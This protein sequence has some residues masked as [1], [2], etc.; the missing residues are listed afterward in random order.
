[1][2]ILH[3]SDLHGELMKIVHNKHHLLSKFDVWIDTGDFFPNDP[4]IEFHMSKYGKPHRSWHID[5]KHEEIFQKRWLEEKDILN[6]LIKW[7]NGRPFVSVSGNH[8]FISLAESLK[9]HGYENV[10]DINPE[11]F[12]LF[13]FKWAGFPHVMPVDLDGPSQWNHE[14][15]HFTML[16]LIKRI[17]ESQP[18]ILIT[19]SPP[20]NILDLGGS[21]PAD[22]WKPLGIPQISLSLSYKPNKILAHFFGHIHE[23]GGKKEYVKDLDITFYNGARHAIMHEIENK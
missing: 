9:E 4:I 16:D 2:K 15:D 18:D 8:D 22:N 3:T 23:Q 20:G 21:G 5:R 17:E 12:E 14:A 13:G 19:H 1:M 6:R 10:Y 7:L 11:G